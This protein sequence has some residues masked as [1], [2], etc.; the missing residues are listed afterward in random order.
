MKFIPLK[1][2]HERIWIGV[3]YGEI[4]RSTLSL[5]ERLPFLETPFTRYSYL[6]QVHGNAVFY[7]DKP[8]KC[9]KA[10]GLITDSTGL[11]LV[12]QTADCVPILLIGNKQV[13]AVHAGWRG[14]ASNIIS[15]ACQ[16]IGEIQ[17]AVIGPCISVQNYEV[18][19]EVVEGI[20]QSGINQELFVERGGY[21]KAHVNLKVVAQQQLMSNGVSNIETMD[22]CTF[23]DSG[24]ASYRR[25]K[26]KSGR[27]LSIIGILPE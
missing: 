6:H 27:I 23:E 22:Y 18:G 20:C 17:S 15:V 3:T 14:L 25:D 10:D 13:A 24:L 1:T 11:A 26:D 8:G 7:S 19:E 16:Q 5:V 12:I 9:G 2:K 4:N 21:L